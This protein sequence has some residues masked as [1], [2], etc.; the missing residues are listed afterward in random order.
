MLPHSRAKDQQFLAFR[1]LLP[2]AIP[3]SLSVW[4]DDEIGG[5]ITHLRSLSAAGLLS[6]SLN[7]VSLPAVSAATKVLTGR[8]LRP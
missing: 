1:L 7:P 4:S 8:Y 3:E 5:K 6:A 2:V